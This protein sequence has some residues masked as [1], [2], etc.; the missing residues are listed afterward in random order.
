MI[1]QQYLTLLKKKTNNG[2]VASRCGGWATRLFWDWGLYDK[3]F[4]LFLG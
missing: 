2:G 3:I 4:I 1:V